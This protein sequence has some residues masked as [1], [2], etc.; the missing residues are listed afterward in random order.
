MS[1]MQS[2]FAF[3]PNHVSQLEDLDRIIRTVVLRNYVGP[4][5]L[6]DAGAVVVTQGSCFA[7][8]LASSLA[9][10]GA[11]VAHLNVNE[12]INTTVA[13][14]M[15]FEHVFK[16]A[17]CDPAIRGLMSRIMDERRVAEFARLVEQCRAFVLTI[18]VAPCWFVKGTDTV[19]LEPDRNRMSSF[20]MRT[21]SVSWNA[22]NIRR[23][24][25]A[26]RRANAGAEIFITLSP[27]PLNAS[28]EYDSIMV[29]DCVSKS[30]L[31]IAID[32]VVREQRP[33]VR[34]WPSFEVV[35]WVGSHLGPVYGAED[36]HPRH[37]SNFV[38][39]AIVRAFIELHGG[40][41][42]P[43]KQGAGSF[44]NTRPFELARNF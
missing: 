11:S 40:E 25:D 32:E 42:R 38:V 23:V 12:Y 24:V 43:S 2:Q 4:P 3:Y 34:Y 22:A 16:G 14:A 1:S 36:S 31:R 21:T 28:S 10:Q 35:R 44:K 8:N 5:V 27:A 29:A 30:V 9:R 19:A 26:I 33:G 7:S 41:L 39:D 18:G 13:N 20:E 6:A 15:F 17:D 37:V